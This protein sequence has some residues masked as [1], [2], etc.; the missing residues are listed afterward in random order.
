MQ[1]SELGNMRTAKWCMQK[2]TLTP[3]S[4]IT[5][6][7]LLV[8][9]TAAVS[10]RLRIVLLIARRTAAVTAKKCTAAL[11]GWRS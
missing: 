5:V 3:V 11:T 7:R 1:N 10:P 4:C 8:L 9:V 2:R 6:L